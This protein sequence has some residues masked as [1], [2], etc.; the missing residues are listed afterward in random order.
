MDEAATVVMIVTVVAGKVALVAGLWLRLRYR[1][2]QD[3]AQLAYLSG[4][5]RD[6]ASRGGCIDL[7]D[8]REGCGRSRLLLTPGSAHLSNDAA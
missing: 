2:Q 8:E 6:V 3:R 4:V 1:A 7:E 5:A